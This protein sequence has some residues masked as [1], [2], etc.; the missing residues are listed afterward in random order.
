MEAEAALKQEENL[1]LGVER[2]REEVQAFSVA[3][4]DFAGKGHATDP[5][6]VKGAEQPGNKFNR[7]LLLEAFSKGSTGAIHLEYSAYKASPA[8]SRL[9]DKLW[10]A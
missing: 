4:K 7:T 10:Q 2:I 5:T 8:S 3:I 9:A 6:E 1:G